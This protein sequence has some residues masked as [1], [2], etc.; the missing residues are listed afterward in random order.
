MNVNEYEKLGAFYLGKK[1]DLNSKKLEDDP[2]LYESK[3][4]TTHA[5]CVGMTGSGKTGLCMVLLE[6][7]LIDGIPSIIIDPKGDIAN[8]LLNFPALDAK[9]FEPWVNKEDASK[10][11]L[12][13]KEYAEQQ[14]KLWKDG[15]NQWN[16]DGS[17]IKKLKDSAQF[18]IYT[19]GSNSG[20]PVSIIKSFAVPSKEIL[21][22]NE[23]LK[24]KISGTVTGL[25]TLIGI[26]ANPIES[27]EHILLST[28][29]DYCWKQGQNL[30]LPALIQYIQTPPMTKIGVLDLESFFPSK[31]RFSL[32][33]SLNNLLASGSFS[34]WMEGESLDLQNIL[35]A[36]D[37]KP[38]ASIFSIAHLN[39]SER[40]FF[41]SILLNQVLSWVRAQSGTTSLR[42]ILYMDE[43]FG[44]FPPVAN[45]P[46]KSPLLTLLKQARAF[47]L[48][49]LLAT[50]NP[51]D[52]DY[53][54]L[55]NTGTWFIGRLQTEQDKARV[56]DGLEGASQSTGKSFDRQNIDKII[57][58]LQNRTFLMSNIHEDGLEVLQSRWALSYL[59]GPLTRDQIKILMEPVRDNLNLSQSKTTN[60]Q[61]TS[62][63]AKNK[64][65]VQPSP[66][67][68]VAS[69]TNFTDQP[70]T[71]SPDITQFFVQPSPDVTSDKN[72]TLVYRP[73]VL[74]AASINF[75]DKPSK[76]DLNREEIF[77]TPV[78]D[79]PVPLEW[80]QSKKSE[81]K[82][83]EL[84]KEPNHALTVEFAPLPSAAAKSSSYETWRKDFVLWLSQNSKVDLLRDP[85]TGLLSA[86]GESEADFR[87]R[88]SQKGRESRD[89][90]AENLRQK[91]APKLA[92]LQER[93][94]K[95]QQRVEI[96]AAQANQLKMHT[97]VSIGATLLGAFMG[98]KAA[99]LS[100]Y[101]RA[102]TAIKGIGRS[103]KEDKDVDSAKDTVENLTQ[104]LLELDSEFKN[105]VSKFAKTEGSQTN[106]DT[107]TIK[108][109]RTNISIK[110]ISLVWLPFEQNSQ[111][112]QDTDLIKPQ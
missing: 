101:G 6:E 11:G 91:Y 25:L 75:I 78:V 16:Q 29:M 41:V 67:T 73:Y 21:N 5:V 35:Y 93:I 10:N 9:D 18:V 84:Q 38:K 71:L 4:L 46:S 15:L 58:S 45:P 107:V 32:V 56:L 87:V 92:A 106:L 83:S 94:R 17:R 23:I 69:I 49:I 47:G 19:P 109:K 40:M 86:P 62:R 96:Q 99:G 53:K 14:A 13:V 95:A 89:E 27:R 22:D 63:S 76:V 26:E 52:L 24:E 60:S 34:T 108:P 68:H 31:E 110:L 70:P 37:G 57:S 82:L 81:I 100:S 80:Q 30:D 103:M 8:L 54:G 20:I 1:L 12:S 65:H 59:R 77:I 51:V 64:D 42:A 104:Q 50:Q 90:T 2:V 48:G 61:M 111:P 105:E 79:G 72:T 43:I 7:A 66:D 88:T 36:Q 39:D 28:I 102:G 85:L 3:D 33:M 112:Q 74:G 97:A 55:S 44:Y 98:R